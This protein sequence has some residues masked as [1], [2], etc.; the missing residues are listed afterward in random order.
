MWKSISQPDPDRFRN[1]TSLLVTPLQRMEVSKMPLPVRLPVITC[2]IHCNH[3]PRL[4]SRSQLHVFQP[5]LLYEVHGPLCIEHRYTFGFGRRPCTEYVGDTHEP[6]VPL[7][8]PTKVRTLTWSKRKSLL[9]IW[10]DALGQALF[11]THQC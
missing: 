7:Q 8:L 11:I 9:S 6:Q 10:V 5:L 1:A 3:H 4:E 2:F